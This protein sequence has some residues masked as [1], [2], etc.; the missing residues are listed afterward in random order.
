MAATIKALVEAEI[1]V[2][3]HV[4]LRPQA[5]RRLGA[6]KVQRSADEILADAQAVAEAGSVRRRAGVHPPRAGRQ[7]HRA[8]CPSPPSASAPARIAT[9]RSW[10]S[11]TCWG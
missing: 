9:A 4:G 7:D 10:S 8:D 1:P 6:Y 5:I 3:G 2:M 11:T